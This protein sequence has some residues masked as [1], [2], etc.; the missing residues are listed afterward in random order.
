MG[1][2]TLRVIEKEKCVDWKEGLGDISNPGKVLLQIAADV[3][4]EVDNFRD[5]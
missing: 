3:P 2:K 4:R 5:S 1:G